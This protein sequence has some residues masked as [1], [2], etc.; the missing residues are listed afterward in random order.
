MHKWSETNNAS[1]ASR[2]AASAQAFIVGI[3]DCGPMLRI[4]IPNF[5]GPPFVAGATARSVFDSYSTLLPIA[6]QTRKDRGGARA[7][8]NRE[9]MRT[10]R[11]SDG[12]FIYAG[13][14]SLS[15]R[16]PQLAGEQSAAR[17]VHR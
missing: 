8:R 12:L 2:S 3:V 17:V 9:R 16:G 1:K 4:A 10:E 6:E 14:G 15:D 13:A 11:R 7:G 5:I